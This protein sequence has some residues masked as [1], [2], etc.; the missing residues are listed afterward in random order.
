MPLDLQV[1]GT[2]EPSATVAV[3]ARRSPASSPRST[4]R[5]AT[6][7]RGPGALHARPSSARGRAAA[8]GGHS[9]ARHRAGGERRSQAR[10]RYRTCRRAASRPASRS[11]P[12]GPT[13]TALE[14]TV[15]ADR[16]AVENASVQL[17]YATI[18]APIS[19]RTGELMVHRRQSGARQRHHAAGHD[20]PGVADQRHVRRPRGAAGRAETLHVA[21][22]VPVERRRRPSGE[23]HASVG[24][25]H[26]RRQ[27]GRSRRPA[28]SGSRARSRTP[29]RTA[30][31][32]SVRQRD[33]HARDRS[34]RH[35][36]PDVGGADRPA[37][38]LRVRVK[39]DQT[40]ELRDGRRSSARAAT[41]PSSASG[42]RRRRD[43]G[44]R[45]PAAAG[46]GHP[47]QRSKRPRSTANE[48]VRAL[49]H[50][51]RSRRR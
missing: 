23:A 34:G 32:R 20:Q 36:R 6:T 31:A 10:Q 46:A 5:K 16:A 30:V 17:Q 44:D 35:R 21:G 11:T 43:R 50:S 12:R 37:G 13:A 29:S 45:R 33:G 26:V 7:S 4:S 41:R 22:H 19:G 47:R 51:A 38:L 27:R 18:T 25:D 49:H 3:R 28:R 9:A 1:I 15:A 8:G 39:G 48:S 24:A 40:A 42:R 2:V 14:A